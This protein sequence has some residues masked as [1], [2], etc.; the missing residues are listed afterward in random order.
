MFDSEKKVF[1]LSVNT[2]I[3][4]C[5]SICFWFI[6]WYFDLTTPSLSLMICKYHLCVAYPLCLLLQKLRSVFD[7][8]EELTDALLS[9]LKS[10]DTSVNKWEVNIFV[11]L[12]NCCCWAPWNQ[13]SPYLFEN[14]FCRVS[15]ILFY[16]WSALPSCLGMFAD[17]LDLAWALCR[18]GME[19]DSDSRITM[20]RPIPL[21]YSV[22]DMNTDNQK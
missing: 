1:G 10:I 3:Y 9:K 14:D 17:S 22:V 21:H 4:P 20:L 12:L 7:K 5:L 2:L 13:Q 15:M 6:C 8:E 19:T 16:Q 18:E 11:E